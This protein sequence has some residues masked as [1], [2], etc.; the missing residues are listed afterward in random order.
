[1]IYYQAVHNDVPES[2]RYGP[3]PCVNIPHLSGQHETYPGKQK[4]MK[5]HKVA[6]DG[7]P[8]L[9]KDQLSNIGF[10]EGRGSSRGT[11]F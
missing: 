1:M 7:V 9:V 8:L 11:F 10:L 3:Y 5:F 2:V 6:L 4:K